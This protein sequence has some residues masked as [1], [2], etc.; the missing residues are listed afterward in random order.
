MRHV[1]IVG[2]GPSGMYCA[3]AILRADPASRIDVIDRLPTPY[4]LVRFGVAPDHQS[5]KAVIRLLE[6]VLAK[7]DVAF[8][9]GVELGRDVTLDELRAAYDAVVIATGAPLDRRLG[10]PGEDLPNVFASGRFVGWYNHHPDHADVDLRRVKAAV[11]VGSGNVALDVARLLAKSDAE[12]D[13]SDLD[14]DVGAAFARS[15]I[16]RISVV[17]RSPAGAMKFTESEVLEFGELARARPMLGMGADLG[18]LDGKAATA[19]RTVV[20][21][22][23]E[24]KPVE[25]VFEFGLKPV[26]FAGDDR[27]TAVRFEDCDGN[28]HER[29]A[30]LAVTC[31]GYGTHGH[32]LLVEDGSLWNDD[33]RI[34][35]GLYAV[36]WAKRGPSGTI[37]T[38]RAEAQIVAKKLVAE[39]AAAG[40]PGR[41]ALAARLAERAVD[42]IDYDAWRRID[43]SEI[44]RAGG[45]RTRRKWRSF[46]DLMA[47]ANASVTPSKTD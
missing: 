35:G 3:E 21:R 30:D 43:A 24:A 9:G 16:E 13:G 31:I 34:A 5:T 40:K 28:V 47:A 11:I 29:D 18:G 15:G 2:S 26:A 17:G 22:T 42:R 20:E 1:A 32:G 23:Y 19:L 37:P 27:V 25:V 46:A 36:G 10:I 4:G 41:D 7:P 39:T 45:S 8:F 6:R 33:G 14:P 38:N 12:F 44:A